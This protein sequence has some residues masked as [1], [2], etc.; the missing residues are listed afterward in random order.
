MAVREGGVVG[1]ASMV[2]GRGGGGG[3]ARLGVVVWALG[4]G[5]ADAGRA[6]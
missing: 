2:A 4:F 6:Q 1:G 5:D 3:G